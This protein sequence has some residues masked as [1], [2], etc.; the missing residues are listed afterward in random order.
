MNG[1]FAHGGHGDA[2]AHLRDIDLVR[3]EVRDLS[4]RLHDIDTLGTRGTGVM[5]QKIL[6]LTNDVAEL[7]AEFRNA[8]KEREELNRLSSRNKAIN[9]RWLIGIS[10]TVV[11]LILG[12]LTLLVDILQHVPV[13]S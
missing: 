9:R 11:G 8:Q 7:R 6:E 4:R 1:D 10:F 12:T 13:H 3:D 5:E 2:V